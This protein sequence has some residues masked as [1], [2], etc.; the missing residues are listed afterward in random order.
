[1]IHESAENYLETILRI[2]N[3]Q[4]KV[5][6]IDIARAL[7]FSKPSIS[8]AMRLLRQNECITMN[9]EGWIELLPKGERIA[10][11]I[12]ERHQLLSKWLIML[13]VDPE[14]ATQD[15]CKME[16]DLSKETF[17]KLKL[18]IASEHPEL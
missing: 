13:G 6:S 2:R 8:R 1:M 5:R 9:E 17:E 7:N 12:L 4:G 14:I 10:N 15:A 11:E 3:E 18:H 16:H